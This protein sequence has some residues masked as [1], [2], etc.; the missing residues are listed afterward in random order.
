MAAISYDS[1]KKTRRVLLTKAQ[2]GIKKKI[3]WLCSFQ[4]VGKFCENFSLTLFVCT[5]LLAMKPYFIAQYR[6]L[7]CRE[8]FCLQIWQLTLLLDH[9]HRK[10][11]RIGDCILRHLMPCCVCDYRYLFRLNPHRLHQF[12]SYEALFDC[13]VKKVRMQGMVLLANLAT[14]F[15]VLIAS[16]ENLRDAHW[17]LSLAQSPTLLWL[18][19]QK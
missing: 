14:Y 16:P 18:I 19:A 2:D 11:T 10:L 17:R 1:G 9:Q 4:R 6:K 7:G 13:T 12:T 5:K 3:Y 15:C 8:W